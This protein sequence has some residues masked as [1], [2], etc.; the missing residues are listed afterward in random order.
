MS[1]IF[2]P[3]VVMLPGIEIP[4]NDTG[5]P[6]IAA[7]KMIVGAVIGAGVNAALV[8]DVGTTAFHAY[9]LRRLRQLAE[10]RE[11]RTEP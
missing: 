3:L 1:L 7:L 6:G 10:Q 2:L 5:L 4:P 11:G 8:S 9:R